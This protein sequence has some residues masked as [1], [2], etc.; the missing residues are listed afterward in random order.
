MSVS[1]VWNAAH[2]P[3]VNPPNMTPG[4]FL[5]NVQAFVN[6]VDTTNYNFPSFY[7]QAVS[8]TVNVKQAVQVSITGKSDG[9]YTAPATNS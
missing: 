4:T 7:V 3:Y 5:T 6:V 9:T 1:G 8:V 2:I